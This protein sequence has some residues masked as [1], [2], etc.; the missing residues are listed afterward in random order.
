MRSI[1]TIAATAAVSLAVAA[2]AVG[3]VHFGSPQAGP[4]TALAT[5]APP[6]AKTVFNVQLTAKDLAKLAAMMNG[7]QTV[8]QQQKATY[9]GATAQRTYAT[10]RSTASR[11][12][13][14]RGTTYRNTSRGS[15]HSGYRC[16][17]SGSRG[18][19]SGSRGRCGC[20]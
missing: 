3:G 18:G 19:Y 2:V 14:Y 7:Q 6:Q 4:A 11:T 10:Y 9:R 8:R 16:S 15:Y 17:W 12:T 5:P 1:K 13:G 20:W